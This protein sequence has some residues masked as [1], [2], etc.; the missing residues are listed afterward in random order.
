LKPDFS[1]ADDARARLTAPK[2]DIGG[3]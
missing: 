3:R 2:E 1:G